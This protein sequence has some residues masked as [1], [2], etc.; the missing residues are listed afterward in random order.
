[1]GGSRVTQK[2]VEKVEKKQEALCQT[3]KGRQDTGPRRGEK[4]SVKE[5]NGKGQGKKL[6]V[7]TGLGSA[8]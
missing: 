8:P 6:G 2:R 1:M 3:K 5:A 4:T 7:G